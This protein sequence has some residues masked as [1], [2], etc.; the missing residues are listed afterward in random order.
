MFNF[1]QS[2]RAITDNFT[3]KRVITESFTE[4][5]VIT[6]PWQQRQTIESISFKTY[7]Q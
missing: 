4:K 7:Q 3:E 5:R 1:L 6:D 2:V